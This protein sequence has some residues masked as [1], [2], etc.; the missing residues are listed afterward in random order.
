MPLWEYFSTTIKT[1]KKKLLLLLYNQ[2]FLSNQNNLFN[3]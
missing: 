3:T 1:K 2:L